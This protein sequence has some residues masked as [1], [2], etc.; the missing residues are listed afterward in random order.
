MTVELPLKR[1][2]VRPPSAIELQ[3]WSA[4]VESP[5]AAAK[6][7]LFD[8]YLPLSR[9][10]ASRHFRVDA[11]NAVP[12]DELFQLACTGLLESIDRFRPELG[13][14]FRYF[15]SRRITGSILNGVARYSEINQQISF[16]KRV[17]RERLASLKDGQSD[18]PSFDDALDILGSVAAGLAIGMMLD[19]S[20][21]SAG[22]D[23]GNA[24]DAYETLA[25]KQVTELLASELRALPERE[26]EIV[27]LHYQE[28]LTF[29]QL[30]TLFGVTKGRISQ[31]HK[32]AIAMLRKRLLKAGTFRLKS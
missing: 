30:G 32:A 26:G 22:E 5:G 12:P 15:A 25:W 16:R 8:H 24:S 9:R 1:Q 10:I 23:P 28:G 4:Y 31:L 11:V 6:A 20:T 21:T 18:Q 3:L 29:E 17:V 7:K 2:P 13:V 19:E 27:R 14:P